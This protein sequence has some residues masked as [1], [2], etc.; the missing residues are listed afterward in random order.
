MLNEKNKTSV[1]NGI[2]PTIMITALIISVSMADI[3]QCENQEA[4]IK[5]QQTI[6]SEI[7]EIKNTNNENVCNANEF[8]NEVPIAKTCLI[9]IPEPEQEAE[10]KLEVPDC[11]TSFK[12]YMDYN[13]ITDDTTK[14]WEL[15]QTAYTDKYGLRKIGTDYCVAVGS[16]YSETVGERFKITLDSDNEFTVIIS[17]LKKDEHTDS[18]NRYSP[19]YDENGDFYSA[20]II[21]FIVDVEQ[22]HS[23]VT[24]LGTVSYYSEF[25]G[26]IVSIEKI[27]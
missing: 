5:N 20:N 11:D 1:S 3:K 4:I 23:M 10:I 2:V 19:V 12:A 13:C 15:Q 21:E 7:L 25:E 9:E 16:Y 18:S 17:D 14:Q 8:V 26:N 24:T 27:N 22:L 6:I